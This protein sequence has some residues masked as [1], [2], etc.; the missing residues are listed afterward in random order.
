MV[1]ILPQT[2]EAH[3]T[4][5]WLHAREAFQTMMPDTE[6]SAL[7]VDIG[8]DGNGLVAFFFLIWDTSGLF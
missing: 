8:T 3:D 5:R 7:K 6:P 1:H 4:L 2:Q